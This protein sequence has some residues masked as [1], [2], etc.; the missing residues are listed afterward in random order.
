MANQ[1]V[2][3]NA[4]YTAAAKRVGTR[5]KIDYV[6]KF[7]LRFT[8]YFM[9][10]GVVVFGERQYSWDLREGGSVDSHAFYIFLRGSICIQKF[11]AKI[12]RLVE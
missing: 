7:M 3:F 9:I 5:E 8:Y 4:Q 2:K 6:P 1:C 11:W 10:N 12:L